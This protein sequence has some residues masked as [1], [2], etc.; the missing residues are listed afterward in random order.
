MIILITLSY[1]QSCPSP[2]HVDFTSYV[3]SGTNDWLVSPYYPSG[4]WAP[5]TGNTG[6]WVSMP[7]APF[8]WDSSACICT[9]TITRSFFL[10]VLPSKVSLYVIV[11][12]YVTATVNGGSSCYVPYN[13]KTLCDMTSSAVKGLNQLKL[14]ATN[15]GGPAG[16]AYKLE[17]YSKLA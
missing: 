2:S 10:P 15:T 16:L 6:G 1:S 14:D 13:K 3:V 9:I 4:T 7:D 11:D 8:I 5:I 12:D 17:A